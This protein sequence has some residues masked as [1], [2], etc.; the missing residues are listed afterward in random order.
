VR[1][2]N[3]RTKSEALSLQQRI[4]K[5]YPNAFIVKDMIQFPKLYT[6]KQSNE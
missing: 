3:F 4:R 2:G 1:V 5:N 6:D